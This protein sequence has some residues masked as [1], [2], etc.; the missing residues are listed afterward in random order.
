MSSSSVYFAALSDASIDDACASLALALGLGEFEI[1]T[2]HEGDDWWE[3]TSVTTKDVLINVSRLGHHSNAAAW[4]WMWG[5]PSA[6]N[7]QVIL[8]GTDDQVT[9][10]K[11]ALERVVGALTPY[12]SDYFTQ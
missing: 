1:D 6:A 12:P 4:R 7:F 11:G 9:R 3:Y 5:A 2:E 8:R 10:A